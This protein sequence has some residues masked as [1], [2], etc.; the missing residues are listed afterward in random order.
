MKLVGFISTLAAVVS[1]AA[2]AKPSSEAI[3]DELLFNFTLP[4]FINR[5]VTMDPRNLNWTSD[6][7]S[8]S[9]DNPFHFPFLNGCR[10]HDFGYRNYKKQRRFNEDTRKEI[11]VNFKLE[12]A[13]YPLQK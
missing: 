8:R 4:K 12:Y 6:G 10:R 13:A 1:A 2:A 5:R 7:C 11:D 3:T 9:P